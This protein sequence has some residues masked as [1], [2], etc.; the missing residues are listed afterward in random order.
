MLAVTSGLSSRA[1]V[2]GDAT[3]AGRVLPPEWVTGPRTTRPTLPRTDVSGK[4][5]GESHRPAVPPQQSVPAHIGEPALVRV[6]GYGQI[7]LAIHA[8][9]SARHRFDAPCR[10][11]SL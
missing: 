8:A 9:P 3:S 5:W 11:R 2:S 7:D 6:D 4:G 1:A 10:H